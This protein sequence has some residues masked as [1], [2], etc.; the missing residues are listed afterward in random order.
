MLLM[1][2]PSEIELRVGGLDLELLNSWLNE[3]L[4]FDNR[5]DKK[6][7]ENY[8]SYLS[9]EF[10]IYKKKIDDAIDEG[11]FNENITTFF[12]EKMGDEWNAMV[13][14]EEK[15]ERV[16][17]DSD[18]FFEENDRNENDRNYRNENNVDENNFQGDN[19]GDNFV[20]QYDENGKQVNN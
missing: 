11:K 20:Q 2:P 4:K 6:I 3:A 7:N 5:L 1:S 17:R 15:N 16:K 10:E 8:F 18:T 13:Q 14:S 12:D 19:G 9:N